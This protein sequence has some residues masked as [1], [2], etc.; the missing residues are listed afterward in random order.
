MA[1]DAVQINVPQLESVE[2]LAREAESLKNKLLEEKAKLNDV[3]C[4]YL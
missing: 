4:K 3:D 1:T 2:Q